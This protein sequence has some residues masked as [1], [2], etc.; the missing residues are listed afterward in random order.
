MWVWQTERVSEWGGVSEWVSEWVTWVSEWVCV[1]VCVC[2]RERESVCVCVCVCVRERVCVCVCVR[3]QRGA[4]V[5]RACVRACVW[6]VFVFVWVCYFFQMI[7]NMY[8]WVSHVCQHRHF[9]LQNCATFQTTLA[10]WSSKSNKR[11]TFYHLLATLAT[12]DNWLGQ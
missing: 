12:F 9:C 10:H 8:Q 5:V 2:V 11:M 1:C 7:P 3:E 4:S 6:C